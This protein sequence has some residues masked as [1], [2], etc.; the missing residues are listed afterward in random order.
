M[1]NLAP[2][3]KFAKN[4]YFINIQKIIYYE[5]KHQI[6]VSTYVEAL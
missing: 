1:I 5:E 3:Q 6:A 2:L 4:L